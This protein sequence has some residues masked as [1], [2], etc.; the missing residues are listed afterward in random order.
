MM[1]KL[2]RCVSTA[3]LALLLISFA[4][5]ASMAETPA[6]TAQ[7]TPLHIDVHFPMVP[8]EAR[9]ADIAVAVDSAV[10]ETVLD[11]VQWLLPYGNV[12]G[13]YEVTLDETDLLSITF[14]YSGYTRHMAHPAHIGKSLTFDMLTGQIITL[15]DLFIDDTYLDIL[16][17]HIAGQIEDQDIPLLRPFERFEAGQDFYLTPTELVIYFQPYDLAPYYWGFPA[18]RVRYDEIED[19]V[20]D[21][22]ISRLIEQNA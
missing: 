2:K 6:S 3:I 18:F 20:N 22:F 1:N 16:S 5:S 13:L 7:T 10:Q 21:P 4:G 8:F 11:M 9:S 19:I 15:A 17:E 14:R 12:S